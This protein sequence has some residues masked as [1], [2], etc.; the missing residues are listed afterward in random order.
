VVVI[1]IITIEY[2]TSS[3][4]AVSIQ[5]VFLLVIKH[6]SVVWA[7]ARLQA[8]LLFIAQLRATVCHVVIRRIELLL[9]T[10]HNHLIL[11]LPWQAQD[12]KNCDLAH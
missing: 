7:P 12:L 11:C 5:E 10:K 8:S 6:S 1:S 9:G 3:T 4:L 2:Y